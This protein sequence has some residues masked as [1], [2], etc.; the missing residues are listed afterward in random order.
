MNFKNYAV[1]FA[2][3]LAAILVV[4]TNRFGPRSSSHTVPAISDVPRVASKYHLRNRVTR[5][6]NRAA[7]LV[8]G[9]AERSTIER[10]A[11]ATQDRYL[12][13]RY[14]GRNR[15]TRFFELP[16]GPTSTGQE[17]RHL[18]RATELTRTPGTQ[19]ASRYH[20]RNRAA[21]FFD[22]ATGLARVPHGESTLSGKV[23]EAITTHQRRLQL[24]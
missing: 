1:S 21:R 24:A 15:T 11:G 16:A 19:L 2:I 8:E 18:E 13:V 22:R 7:G 10:K 14:H 9:G 23:H 6:F 3:L 5:P 17:A 4:N 20:L 12:T